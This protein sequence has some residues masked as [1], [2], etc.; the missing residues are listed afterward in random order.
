MPVAVG[1]DPVVE[2]GDGAEF[3]EAGLARWP[4][5]IGFDEGNGVVDV[6][7]PAGGGGVGEAVDRDGQVDGFA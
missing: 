4:T 7:G 5:L 1:F 3:A 6:A 2:A